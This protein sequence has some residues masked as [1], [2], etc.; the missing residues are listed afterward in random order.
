MIKYS[1]QRE[2]IRRCLTGRTDHPTAET[3]YLEIKEQFPNISLGTVYRNLALLAEQ[4]EILKISTGTGPDRFDWRT[5]PHCHLQCSKC[6]RVM[7]LAFT[8]DFDIDAMAAEHF[9]GI[10]EAHTIQFYGVCPDCV[11]H[12]D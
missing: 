6:G 4:G 3:I 11:Q 7:D 8:P 9:D 1:R 12:T 2:S 5:T 10:I